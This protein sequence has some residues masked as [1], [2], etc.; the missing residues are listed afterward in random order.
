MCS[1][2]ETFALVS[3]A[4]INPVRFAE[5]IEFIHQGLEKGIPVLVLR[6]TG[7]DEGAYNILFPMPYLRGKVEVEKDDGSSRMLVPLSKL[8]PIKLDLKRDICRCGEE[9]FSAELPEPLP[10]PAV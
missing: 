1:K 3:T 5:H 10:R 2:P 7:D 9:A 4:G 6:G 8:K